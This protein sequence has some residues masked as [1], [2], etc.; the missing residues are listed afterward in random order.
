MFRSSPRHLRIPMPALPRRR[1]SRLRVFG[2]LTLILLV[3]AVGLPLTRATA[4]RQSQ[5]V[6]SVKCNLSHSAPDDPIV[7]PL[8]RGRSHLHDFFG[9]VSVNADTTTASLIRAASTCLKGMGEVDRAAYWTPALLRGGRP[10]AGPPDEH[11]IDAYYA[12]LDKQ[13]P[14]KPMPFGLRMVAGDAKAT[15]PQS[16]DIVHYNC[17]RYPNGGQAGKSS[18]AIPNCPP[19]TYLSA[20]I[21]FPGCW[22]GRNLD[23]PDHKSHMAYPVRGRCPVSHPVGLPSLSI[24]L[25]WKTAR[26]IPSSQLAL[27][28]RGQFSMH[29]DFWN[30]WSPS[31][32][33]WLT[34]NCLNDTRNC[35]DIA[36]NQVA[37][38]TGSFP[39]V[40]DAGQGSTAAAAGGSGSPPSSAPVGSGVRPDRPSTQAVCPRSDFPTRR[41]R[42]ACRQ[43]IGDALVHHTGRG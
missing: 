20:K 16:T 10:V 34:S 23:S 8:Q 7:L 43:E 38:A 36:R 24:R 35:T 41:A 31:V 29:A 15:S 25:R 12:V 11:R 28:S 37:A 18:A 6:W 17:L 26:G 22:D 9:N 4:L 14:V 21:V 1:H 27:S 39:S 3:I 2:V 33:Q 42:R 13:L 32:M 40:G 30:V 5:A 19:G